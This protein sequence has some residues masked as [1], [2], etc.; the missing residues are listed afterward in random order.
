MFL[1]HE[2]SVNS[3]YLLNEIGQSTETCGI[4]HVMLLCHGFASEVFG[5]LFHCILAGE[6]KKVT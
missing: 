6:E 4:T 1:G 5:F 2:L 3:D